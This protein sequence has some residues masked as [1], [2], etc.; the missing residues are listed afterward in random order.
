MK[1]GERLWR[2][3]RDVAGVLPRTHG[4][5]ASTGD[6]NP[7]TVGGARVFGEVLLDEL[8]LTGMTLTSPPPRL[9]RTVP[10]CR[11]AA[12]Q[13]SARGVAGAHHVPE[14]LRVRSLQRRRFAGTDFERLSFDHDP[15]LPDVLCEGGWGTPAT[16]VAHLMR[17]VGERRPWL[18]WV[19]GAG[20]GTPMDLVVSRAR[21]IRDRL[22][23]NVALPVQPG[24]GIRRAAPP[25]YPTMDPL[26][27]VA[28]MMR[29]VS[30]IRALVR[31][32]RPQGSALA[33]AGVSMG[34]PVAGLVAHLE[35]VDA[36][37]LFTPIFGLNAMI[38][39]HLGRWGPS[40]RETVELLGSAPVAEL[41]SIVD[42]MS[43]EPTAPPH[44]R[45][46]VGAWQDQMARR[47][48][49]IEVHR[50]WGGE[51]YWHPGSHV[52]HLWAPGVRAETDRFLRVLTEPSN[53]G[54]R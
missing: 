37:A 5:V 41:A 52:G 30:E 53:G 13:L 35:P 39:A 24:C 54:A 6:W 28:Q 36:V 50:T 29:A 40:V 31:W 38:A 16:A 20:Q 26:N 42:Y 49:A 8:A 43:V 12:A 19:H 11:A 10:S 4:A 23:V 9:E 21:H 17:T 48:P 22:G 45:L 25:A 46:V 1:V 33:V 47:E 2:I 27:N 32:L 44:R 3:G 51:L 18:V 7:L 14:P 34:S 15:L